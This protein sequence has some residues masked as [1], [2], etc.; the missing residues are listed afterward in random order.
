[1]SI[2]GKV[3]VDNYNKKN[4]EDLPS[5]DFESGIFPGS[6]RNESVEG[7]HLIPAEQRVSDV[8]SRMFEE[9]K[10]TR[11]VALLA[12]NSPWGTSFVL[13]RHATIAGSGR[14]W[15]R[16]SSI[17]H[18]TPQTPYTIMWRLCISPQDS[19]TPHTCWR[20]QRLTAGLNEDRGAGIS[21]FLRGVLC[22]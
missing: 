7:Y 19:W 10:Q 21:T 15:K 1:M 20:S 22:D 12:H 8:R 6:R 11:M 3:W 4:E 5:L 2:N 9:K 13:V 14:S 17:L 18:A 16:F